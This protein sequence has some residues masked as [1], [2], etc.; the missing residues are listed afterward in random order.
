MLE[1]ML[2][3]TEPQIVLEGWNLIQAFKGDIRQY[4][5]RN[6]TSNQIFWPLYLLSLAF[7]QMK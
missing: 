6:A 7:I 4:M 5:H 1:R 2:K 3:E